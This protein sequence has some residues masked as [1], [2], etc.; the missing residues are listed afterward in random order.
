MLWQVNERALRDDS[1]GEKEPNSDE[2]THAEA[3]TQSTQIAVV[4]FVWCKEKMKKKSMVAWMKYQTRH[5]DDIV[6]LSMIMNQL[7]KMPT[8]NVCTPLLK[9]KATSSTQLL[10]F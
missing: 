5:N 9:E 4:K 6:Y 2:K 3:K 10:I 8:H 1:T 7:N